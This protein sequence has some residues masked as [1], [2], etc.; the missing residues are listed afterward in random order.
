MIYVVDFCSGE[1]WNAA[2][3]YISLKIKLFMTNP[4]GKAKEGRNKPDYTNKHKTSVP[5]LIDQVISEADII[6]EVLD[7]RFI[8]KTRNV[9]LENKIKSLGKV[10]I[11]IFNKSDLVDINKIKLEEDY[12]DLKPSLFFSS[13]NRK[14]SATLVRMIKI[15][16]KK[17]KKD[18]VNI[19][20]I[21]YPNTGKSSMINL[22]AGRAVSR[23]SSEAGF[24][25]GIQKIKIFSGVY[26]ID[27]PGI[28]PI[29]EKTY[30]NRKLLAKHAKIGATTWYKAK[31]PDVIVVEI[32]KEYPGMLEAHYN[33]PADG[34]VEV[35]I[36]KL[37]RRLSYLKK[38]NEVDEDRTAK[39]ILRQWQE[40]KIRVR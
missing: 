28:I 5:S 14:G 7:A 10:L 21:G 22:L 19:G 4:L 38:G 31:D 3:Y 26:L 9:E 40:G 24:T 12:G 32:M 37:G 15:Q 25:K 34:D 6:L 30:G 23:T 16:V 8:E 39:H 36:E 13:T 18:A 2:N 27:T 20:V 17:I 1:K 35:L 33:I 29:E 11:Y